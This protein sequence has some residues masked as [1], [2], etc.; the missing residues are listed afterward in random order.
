MSLKGTIAA[1]LPVLVVAGVADAQT[2]GEVTLANAGTLTCTTGESPLQ[3]SVDAELSCIFRA[4][5][6]MEGN[7]TGYIA[8]RGEADLPP[9]KRVLVWAVLAPD[10]DI[11]AEALV[12]TYAGQTGGQRV[13][14]LVGGERRDIVLEPATATSQIGDM[15]A[16]TALELRLEPLKA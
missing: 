3:A 15:P 13:D 14:R 9:G 12:G 5:S 1:A 7:F 2:K 6:G 4:R 10:A 8:R 16:P 11:R